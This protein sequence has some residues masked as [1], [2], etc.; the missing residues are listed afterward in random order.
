MK[1]PILVTTRLD[2]RSLRGGSWDDPR[3]ESRVPYRGLYES[4]DMDLFILPGD[5]VYGLRIFRSLK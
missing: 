2:F 5:A 1:N 4:P 3:K